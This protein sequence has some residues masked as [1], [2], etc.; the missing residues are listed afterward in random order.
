MP[1]WRPVRRKIVGGVLT[2]CAV[3]GLYYTAACFLFVK[4]EP[5]VV[6]ARMERRSTDPETAGLRP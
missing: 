3:F 4:Y 5:A 1:E 6:F 2:F